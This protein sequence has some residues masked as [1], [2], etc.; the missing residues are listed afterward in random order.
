MRAGGAVV[1]EAPVAGGN[2]YLL[3]VSAR[4]LDP[5]GAA[6]LNLHWRD[7][8]GSA[9][10]VTSEPVIPGATMSEQFLW[11]VAPDRA[12]SVVVELAASSGTSCDFDEAT[13]YGPS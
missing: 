12:A 13:L 9:L 10:G 1:Q 5:N 11:R 8:R 6:V 2:P 4:C 3:E 7:D